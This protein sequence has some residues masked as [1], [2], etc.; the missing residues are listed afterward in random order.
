MRHF[1]RGVIIKS[2]GAA[3]GQP[4]PASAGIGQSHDARLAGTEALGEWRVEGWR[5]QVQKRIE[6]L[7]AAGL[8]TMNGSSW[9]WGLGGVLRGTGG[10]L[11]VGNCQTVTI[12]AW[13]TLSYVVSHWP[14]YINVH[15]AMTLFTFALVCEVTF[16]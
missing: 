8:G 14:I 5:G 4:G 2:P 13:G 10:L 1:Y 9:Q 3:I 16:L 12:A 15:T 7:Q 6:P 11:G